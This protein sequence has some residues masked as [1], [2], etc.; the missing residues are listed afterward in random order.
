[1]PTTR[2]SN[3]LTQLLFLASI[4]AGIGFAQDQPAN[5]SPAH[6]ESVHS[7][8]T[9]A[10]SY[11]TPPQRRFVL[12]VINS[13]V[14][15]EE[16]D[17]Q[18]RLRVLAAA[19]ELAASVNP[20]LAKRLGDEGSQLELRIVES[21]TPPA[22]SII[23]TGKVGCAAVETFI[24]NLSAANVALAEQSVTAAVSKCSKQTLGRVRVLLDTALDQHVV[25]PRAL[26]AAMNQSGTKSE[27]SQK[28]FEKVF[29]SLPKDS[30]LAKTQAPLFAQLYATMAPNVD[31]Q[32]VSHAGLKLLDWL[33]AL[34]DSGSRSVAVSMTTSSMQKALGPKEYAEAI[35]ADMTAL[36]LTQLAGQHA[37]IELP[38]EESAS[39]MQATQRLGVDR[40]ELL[41]NMPASKRAREAAADGFASGKAGDRGQSNRYFDIAYGAL[42]EVWSSRGQ[43]ENIAALLEEVNE[44]AAQ[45]D[46]ISALQR[47]QK[48]EDPAAQAI[49]MLAVA[50]VVAGTQQR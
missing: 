9:V 31:K 44:A 40:T 41:R 46:S 14:A 19:S 17:L 34:E 16:S 26:L 5:T 35:R 48:L 1:M 39:V 23:S 29:G 50:R 4:F 30:P 3:H 27:W 2:K 42:N 22:V 43:Q 18:D 45:I 47:A 8:T 11:A 7:K 33:A 36:S 38:E 15:L 13:A 12:D 28:E 32:T 49:G 25:A 37:Q 6:P 21:G 20:K 24:D 10:R